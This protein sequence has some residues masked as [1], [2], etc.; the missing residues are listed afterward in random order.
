[1]YKRLEVII[2]LEKTYTK[3]ANCKAQMVGTL[4]PGIVESN[5]LIPLRRKIAYLKYHPNYKH[6]DFS[7]AWKIANEL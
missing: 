6:L 3:W 2:A 4:Y 1:M 7:I 5:Y